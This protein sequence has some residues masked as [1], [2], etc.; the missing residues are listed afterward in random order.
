MSMEIALVS[1]SMI[2]L[3]AD[4]RCSIIEPN[5]TK[6]PIHDNMQKIKRITPQTYIATGGLNQCMSIFD[7]LLQAE[8]FNGSVFRFESLSEIGIEKITELCRISDKQFRLQGN[9][10]P[11]NATTISI[12][13]IDWSSGPQ[14]GIFDPKH[15]YVPTFQCHNGAVFCKSAISPVEFLPELKKIHD[16][17]YSRDPVDFF[18]AVFLRAS[19]MDPSISSSFDLSY[20]TL[21]NVVDTASKG[22]LTSFNT[23]NYLDVTLNSSGYLTGYKIVDGSIEDI[24]IINLTAE[25]IIAGSVLIDVN[26]IVGSGNN[27]FKSDTN[28]IYL[29]NAT[30]ANAPFRVTMEGD[31]YATNANIT[32]SINAGSTITGATITGGSINVE[33][34]LHVGNSIYVGDSEEAGKSII[35]RSS[36]S[37]DSVETGIADITIDCEVLK[38]DTPL[39]QVGLNL[40]TLGDTV[41]V[42]G[43]WDF[44]DATVIGIESDISGASDVFQSLD[45]KTVTVDN[46]IITSI[47]V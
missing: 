24:K 15:D 39:T 25:K 40:G 34:D 20:L 27:V 9:D 21:K 4:K 22:L 18:K 30:F 45:G 14:V 12:V 17:N 6:T 38:L 47:V 26:M 19:E 11:P 32:G 3:A 31:L 29:G 43:E 13:L 7:G 36:A 42:Q 41:Y 10:F 35:F 16:E 46:G 5:G 44:S 1:D 2:F 33:T 8:F 37:I 28:G 23:S